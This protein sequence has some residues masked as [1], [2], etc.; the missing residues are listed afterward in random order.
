MGGLLFTIM[1]NQVRRQLTIKGRWFVHV[2]PNPTGA[3]V[4]EELDVLSPPVANLRPP[5]VREDRITG[6]NPPDK[7][8]P[9]RIFDEVALLNPLLVNIIAVLIL[10][11]TGIE[12]RH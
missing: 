2:I 8:G 3:H 9:V 10:L 12:D 11:N 1:E 6:S 5:K 4:S 7:D